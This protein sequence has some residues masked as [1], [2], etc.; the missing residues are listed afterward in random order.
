MI[1]NSIEVSSIHSLQHKIT[2]VEP[3]SDRCWMGMCVFPFASRVYIVY[4][5][6]TH[7]NVQIKRALRPN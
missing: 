4:T 7:T 6:S 1:Y 2:I 5:C 3:S